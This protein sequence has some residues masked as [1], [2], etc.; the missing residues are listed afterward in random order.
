MF[1]E[2]IIEFELRGP[3]PPG[4]TC[5]AKTGYFFG[6]TKISK[7]NK[8]SSELLLTSTYAYCKRQCALLPFTWTKSITKFIKKML[9]FQREF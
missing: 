5:N 2:Q 9:R 6:K 8:S 3:G 1:I 4:R 7:E